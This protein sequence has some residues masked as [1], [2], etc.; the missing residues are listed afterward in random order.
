MT[1]TKI[2]SPCPWI[3]NTTITWV[4]RVQIPQLSLV[5][6]NHNTTINPDGMQYFKYWISMIY[7]SAE[8]Y[9]KYQRYCVI[10][11][12]GILDGE[13]YMAS[14]WMKDMHII[15]YIKDME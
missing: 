9:T 6:Q 5:L 11:C 4:T 14:Y 13:Y 12:D 7:W 8:L 1:T 2:V 3:L 15:A 10:Y